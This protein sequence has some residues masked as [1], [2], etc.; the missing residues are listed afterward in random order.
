MKY[1]VIIISTLL[2]LSASVWA[3]PCKKTKLSEASK[4]ALK[5][6]HDNQIYPIKKAVYDQLLVSLSD[7]DRALLDA[8]RVEFKALEVEVRA[9]KEQLRN[10]RQA[11]KESDYKTMMAPIREKRKAIME[12]L[13]PLLEGN[14]DVIQQAMQELKGH[15][16]TWKAA[17]EDI[18]KQNESA[19]T[20]DALKACREHHKA[21]KGHH[22]GAK[23]AQFLL[24]DGKPKAYKG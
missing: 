19:G 17:R 13:Q 9:V 20:L 7:A 1:L 12:A 10:D 4:T 14:K 21:R 8:K 5:T 18:L 15:K 11:G 6:Y 2:L 24:W 22:K 16:E 3:Q 23:V